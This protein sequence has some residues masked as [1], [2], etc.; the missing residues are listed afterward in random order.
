MTGRYSCCRA[1]PCWPRVRVKYCTGDTPR[2]DR[3]RGGR[4]AHRDAWARAGVPMPA[5]GSMAEP[6]PAAP[7]AR[8]F[9]CARCQREVLVCSPCDRGQRYCGK[10][11]S[12]QARRA[13]MRAAGRRYQSSRAGQFAHARRARR[14]RQRRRQQIVTH[15]GSQVRQGGDVLGADLNATNPTAA[16]T[17]CT[18]AVP[19]PRTCH[20]CARRCGPLRRGWM[21]GE[22]VRRDPAAPCRQPTPHGQSP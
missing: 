4:A 3:L 7:S 20:W 2:P 22:A 1:P 18:A 12:N 16:A 17:A 14:Y 11:C 6:M 9:V 10:G 8:R 19:P 21:R 15:Q 13:S 5:A